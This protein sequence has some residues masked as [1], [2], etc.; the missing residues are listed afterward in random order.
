METIIVAILGSSVLSALISGI[1]NA[2]NNS[3]KQ[4]REV[5]D[6]LVIINNRLSTIEKNQVVGEKDQLRTQLL[7][8][9]S[10]YP[11]EHAEILE[12]AKHYFEDLDGNWYLSSLFNKW[13]TE[14][15]ITKPSWFKA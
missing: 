15:N 9:I 12:L 14:E 3:K 2:I 8:M 11:E 5:A 4:K 13:L 1:F 7:M 6:Q 10:D